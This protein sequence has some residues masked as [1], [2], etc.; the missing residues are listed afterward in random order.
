MAKPIKIYLCDLVHNY[1]GVGSYMF[2]LNIGYLSVYAK[3][4][5]VNEVEIELFKYPKDFMDEF[6][7][8]KCDIVGFSNYIWSA[9]LNKK[10][11]DWIKS[12]SP[13]TIVVFG[14]PNID[15]TQEAYKR[16]FSNHPSADFYV[17]YQGEIALLNILKKVLE[18]GNDL[19]IL[20]AEP[21][22]GVV[23]YDK[24]KD[25]AVQGDLIPR[26]KDL[27]SVPS[28]YLTG[29]LDKFF[30]M[31]LIPIVET[32]RGCPYRCTYCC[33]GFSSYN[34]INFFN[35]ERAKQELTYIAH[36]VKKTNI[37]IFADSNFGIL[38]RDI[39]ISK[40]IAQLIQETGYPRRVSMNWAKNQPK[41]FEIA[42]IL[43]NINLI[44]SL[45]SLD[46][47]VLKNIKRQNVSA[48]IFKDIINKINQEG[49]I[50]GTEI[51]LALP[52]ETKQS[53][54]E[55]LRK[56]FDLNVSYITC[57]NCFILEGS[58]MSNQRKSGEL[59]CETKFRLV[60]NAFG[61]YGEIVSFETEE[62]IRKLETM[63]EEEIL[64]F[65]PV[66]WLIQ[67]LWNYRFYYDLLKYLQSLGINPLDY[68][69]RLIENVEN[70]DTPEKIKEIFQ[71]FKQEAKAEWF[72]SPE[73]V[74]EHYS[75]PENFRWLEEG[76]FGKM[77]SKY[78]F[79][80]VLGVKDDFEKYLYNT[81]VNYS[82]LANSK[83]LIINEILSFLSSAIIDFNKEWEDIPKERSIK[84]NYDILRW[85]GSCY[86]EKLDGLYQSEKT[87][88]LY[89]LPEAQKKSLQ[90]LLKQYNHPNKNVT[91]RKMSEYMDIR[92]C[93]YKVKL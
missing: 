57:Y 90:I 34:Q 78:I 33:Q 87:I 19:S 74:R 27:E 68:M 85:R 30:E 75:R 6:E 67:F 89:F 81:A 50:S 86:Q 40:H 64:Y 24:E 46:E 49:G 48:E 43:K 29:V 9:D 16:F 70:S 71:Q 41:I 22:D 20:K 7:K 72:D 42:K 54:L 84:F 36:K 15:Y 8:E 66:H 83:K 2:P 56:L 39:E 52:G 37:L 88:F 47:V 76:N 38:E 5:L 63:S 14:G 58:E 69:V 55:S 93:F 17:I 4:F 77:N 51:I 11:S 65:R 12:K 82:S 44:I 61:K 79:K 73:A 28:P 18:K 25:I 91:L 80:V 53:H 35:I 45:Q 23:F 31:N 3:K 10:M 92:D 32:N 26:I 13:Q 1:S 21:I 62:G 59:K 60:D